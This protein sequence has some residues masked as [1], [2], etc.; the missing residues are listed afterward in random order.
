M[1]IIEKLLNMIFSLFHFDELWTLTLINK[2]K[3]KP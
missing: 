2:F 3:I 1:Y